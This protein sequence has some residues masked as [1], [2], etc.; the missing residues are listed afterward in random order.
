M[1]HSSPDDTTL[2][3][4]RKLL[5]M[6]ER[7]ENI[8]EADA[9]SRKAADLVAK[10]RISDDELRERDPSELAI[11]E[12]ILGRG[13][14]VRAR[15]H[16]L[17]GIADANGCIATFMTG[18]AGTTGH[19]TGYRRD[20][21]VVRVLFSSLHSQM[22][23]RA[24]AERRSTGAAT[25]RYRRSFMFGF[26]AQVTEMMQAAHDDAVASHADPSSIHPVL[27]ARHECVKEFAGE[28]LG[29]IVT[30]RAAAP[31]GIDGVI[32]G[33]RA[34]SEADIGRPRFPTRAALEAG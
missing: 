30:A 24:A 4:V 33:R 9:F 25:Q 1:K 28:R 11:E 20:V 8:D 7:T 12:V 19:I 32:A 18:D 29:R 14:Y 22:S 13:A 27:V 17:A 6:A 5:A 34:A 2:S 31:A 15:F 3:R 23:S 26:A 10:Y 21:D 16:L